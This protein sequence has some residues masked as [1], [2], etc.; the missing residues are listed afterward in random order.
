M[1]QTLEHFREH[2]ST[3]CPDITEDE[4][5][6]FLSGVKVVELPARSVYL[7]TGDVPRQVGF[8]V[9]GLIR[10]MHDDVDG[11]QTNVNFIHEGM[12]AVHYQALVEQKPSKYTLQC[13]EFCALAEIP[14]D[15]LQQTMAHIPRFERY[16][17]IAIEKS[18]F[19]YMQRIDSLL[20][21]NAEMRYRDF[22]RNNP[23]LFRRLSVSDL[24]SFLGIQR[25][26][27]TRIRKKLLNS[28]T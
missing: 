22:V 19:A 1:S 2:I 6:R 7:K 3:L 26:S 28:S 27:L 9:N 11:N 20:I 23:A 12:F 16:V 4:L 24:A 14:F 17:R 18:L 5:T 25:Q 13:I 21:Q 15:H 8:V 10:A